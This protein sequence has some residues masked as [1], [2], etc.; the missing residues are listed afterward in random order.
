MYL[1]SVIKKSGNHSEVL[2]LGS[3][4]NVV[5]KLKLLKPDVVGFYVTSDFKDR[6]IEIIK[7]IKKHFEIPCIVGGPHPTFAPEY[8]Q[9]GPIDF[10]CQGEGEKT[11]F[12]F[13]KNMGLHKKEISINNLWRREK[14]NIF[15]A[16]IGELIQNLD[17]IP[18]TDFSI[19]KAYP[20]VV[21]YYK[22]AFPI[23]TSRGCPLK[24]SFCFNERYY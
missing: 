17:D 7:L 13:I 6:C 16:S 5:E 9:E 1:S 10:L 24:C 18:F 12:E 14:D 2:I 11:I 8:I 3:K 23:I 21:N 15:E 20:H 4:V 22:F 19:Y